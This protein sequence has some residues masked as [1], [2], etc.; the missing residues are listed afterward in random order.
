MVSDEG[1]IG[2]G[3]DERKIGMGRDEGKEKEEGVRGIFE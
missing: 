2:M 3:R 1:N